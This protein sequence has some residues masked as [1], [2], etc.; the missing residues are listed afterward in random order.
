M[1]IRSDENEHRMKQKQNK[2]KT[3]LFNQRLRKISTAL[4]QIVKELK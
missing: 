2:K 1:N 4:P 3:H